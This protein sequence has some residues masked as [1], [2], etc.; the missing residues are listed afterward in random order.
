[1]VQMANSEQPV[2][3]PATASAAAPQAA[4][5]G[6]PTP[7]L[8]ALLPDDAIV[9]GG[10]ARTRDEAIDEAGQLLVATG[11]VDPAYVASMH[12]R[13]RSVSTYV[14]NSLAIPHG[15]NEAKQSIRSTGLSFI[16]YADGIDWNG[17]GQLAHFVVGIAGAGDDHLTL[18]GSLAHVF[19]D[20]EK[21][22][23]LTAATSK[24]DVA[25]VL[26]SVALA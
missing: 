5:A 21:V 1:M 6:A 9:L 15:T 24:S 3:V 7:G 14:G 26:E 18:L 25:A 13:E 23:A 20:E 2:T 8:R 4:A 19:L 22:A 16:R 11:A 10:T 12:D 17:D